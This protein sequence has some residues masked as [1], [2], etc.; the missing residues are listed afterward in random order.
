MN[1]FLKRVAI[2]VAALAGLWLLSA[3]ILIGTAAPTFAAKPLV[4]TK[5]AA[6][7]AAAADTRCFSARDGKVL[8][9]GYIAATAADRPTIV[10]L[11]GVMSSAAE[12]QPAAQALHAASGAAIVSLDLRGHGASAGAFGD[13]DHIGQYE[14]DVAD[15]VGAL[16]NAEP[17]RRIILA[18]HSM[19]GG[20]AM[21]YAARRTLPA[22]DGYLL[23][24]PHL[25]ERAPTTTHDSGAVAAGAEAPIKLHLH[26]TI[27]LLMF[28][29][30]GIRAFNGLGTLYFN[31]ADADGL[32]HYS[33]RAMATCAPDD[34]RDALDAD[35]KPLLI[36]AGSRD[37]AFNAAAY[38]EVAR[39]HRGGEALIVEGVTHDGILR[40]PQAIAAAAEWMQ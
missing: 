35:A 26:R 12:M 29:V 22:V 32:L 25:G 27:G 10:L 20:V 8:H 40:S 37:E 5:R 4:V 30:L 6:A 13:I 18:G 36:V 28:N 16:R 24:A 9:A 1:R 39:L 34:Y 23:F 17:A 21:R 31:V 19:G 2:T 38:G 11:H 7:C 33:F 15:V 3:A 14:E